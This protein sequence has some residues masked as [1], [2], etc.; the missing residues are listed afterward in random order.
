MLLKQ[1]NIVAYSQV[2]RIH[3][4]Q[5]KLTYQ[6]YQVLFYEYLLLNIIC[7]SDKFPE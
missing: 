2:C 7:Q 6:V 5:S 4:K 1:A 3:T